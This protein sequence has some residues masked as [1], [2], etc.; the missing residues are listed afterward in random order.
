MIFFT[1]IPEKHKLEGYKLEGYTFT[2]NVIKITSSHQMFQPDPQLA[3]MQSL[4]FK[5]HLFSCTASAA[6]SVDYT[7]DYYC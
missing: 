7:V 4:P 3:T 2:T 5:K 6:T 1:E